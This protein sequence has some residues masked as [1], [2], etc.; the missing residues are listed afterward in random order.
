MHVDDAALRG[1]TG[2]SALPLETVKRLAC[3]GS[4]VRVVEN[5]RGEPLDVG[6]KMRTVSTAIRRALWARDRG[7]AF[8]GCTN[9]RFVDAHHVRHWIDGG[10]TSVENTL[11]LCSHHP[12]L[13]HEGGFRIRR[14]ADGEI[15]FER[16]DGR[17]IPKGGYEPDDARADPIHLEGGSTDYDCMPCAAEPKRSASAP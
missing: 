13:V 12:A 5:A 7:C 4:L 8:P 16:P 10:E 17:V 3:D 11:L 15:F 6:R 1:G 9:T 14:D 2:R